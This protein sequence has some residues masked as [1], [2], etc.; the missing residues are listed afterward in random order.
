[1]DALGTVR[2]F[3]YSWQTTWGVPKTGPP[4]T[5][6]TASKLVVTADHTALVTD[7][8]DIVFV[9]AV[10][11][12]SSGRVVTSSSAPITF[13]VTGPGTIEAVDSASMVQETFR[14][15]VRNAYQGVAFALVQANGP[16]MI[17]VTASASGLNG[18][19]ASIQASAGTFVPC[20]GTCD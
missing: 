7:L 8:N 18:G 16:G 20:S 12:D 9:K 2:S 3:G 6:T 11:A 19:T 10:V 5:G 15:N 13:V 1:M 4:A 14:G 17:T